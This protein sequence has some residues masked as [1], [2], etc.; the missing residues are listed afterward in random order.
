M[1]MKLIKIFTFLA[2]VTFTLSGCSDTK[3]VTPETEGEKLITMFP[4]LSPSRWLSKREVIVLGEEGVNHI[5]KG[6]FKTRS[7]FLSYDCLLYTSP[8]PRDNR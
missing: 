8:S 1:V 2:L 5:R 3:L 6:W 7:S 4:I